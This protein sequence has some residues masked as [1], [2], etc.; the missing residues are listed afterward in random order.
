MK[1]KAL[2]QIYIYSYIAVNTATDLCDLITWHKHLHAWVK[3]HSS[4]QIKWLLHM[5]LSLKS[6]NQLT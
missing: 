1:E 5:K 6:T 4:V 3:F 2:Y